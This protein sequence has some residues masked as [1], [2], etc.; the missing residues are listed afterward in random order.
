MP[1]KFNHKSFFDGI[2]AHID[3]TLEQGQVDGFEFILTSMEGDPFWKDVRQ[4]AY[5]FATIYHETA[6]SMQPV[7]EGYYLGDEARV[8]RFQRTLRYYPYFGR[9]YVQLTWDYNYEKAA[10]ILHLDL[11]NKPELALERETAYKVLTFGMHQGWFTGKK[12]SDYISDTGVDYKNARKIINGTDKAGLIAGYAKTFEQILRSSKVSAAVPV[13]E[14]E[15][16]Q[17]PSNEPSPDD[18]PSQIQVV[19]ATESTVITETTTKG[20]A[21]G[22]PPV[23]VSKG[24]GVTH[25]LALFGGPAAIATAVWGFVTNNGSAIATGMVCMTVIILAVIFRK[26]ILDYLRMQVAADPDKK[27]VT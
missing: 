15:D 26:A 14:R 4:M 27:N 6:A 19:K 2:K 1:M 17:P 12:L 10:A 25:A 8:T 11:V 16:A 22:V 9:G 5:A 23:Q 13:P 18:Q 24:Q 20:D 7:E 21:P 3:S